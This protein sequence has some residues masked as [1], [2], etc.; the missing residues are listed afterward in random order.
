MR[1]LD[2]SAG[3]WMLWAAIPCLLISIAAAAAPPPPEAKFY[4][5]TPHSM[6]PSPDGR[7]LAFGRSSSEADSGHYAMTFSVY[8]V[9]RGKTTELGAYNYGSLNFGPR[10][11][12]SPNGELLAYYAVV[13]DVLQ[14]RVWDRKQGRLLPGTIPVDKAGAAELQI[15]QWTPDGRYV[16]C[17]SNANPPKKLWEEQEGDNYTARLRAELVGQRPAKNGI[18][19]LGTAALESPLKGKFGADPNSSSA[20]VSRTAARQVAA[21][22]VKTG[23]VQVLAQGEEFVQLQVSD[24]GKV[25]VAG[26]LDAHGD[27]L[28]Y[29]LPL[30]DGPTPTPLRLLFKSSQAEPFQNF[31]LSPSGRYA[32]Y[33]VEGSGEIVL[34]D[35]VAGSKRNLTAGVA[36]LKPDAPQAA[37]ERIAARFDLPLYKGKFGLDGG[38]A[39]VWTKDESALIVRRTIAQPSVTAPQRVE[40]WRVLCADGTARRIVDESTFSIVS[41]ANCHTRGRV[42]CLAGPQGA[43]LALVRSP[44]PN[45]KE[46]RSLSYA[47]IDPQSGAVRILRR[48]LA[49]AGGDNFMTAQSTGDV[50]SVEDSISQPQTLWWTSTANGTA[51]PI[52]RSLSL[53]NPDPPPLLGIAQRLEWTSAS[54]EPLFGALRLPFDYREGERLP[55]LLDVYPGRRGLERSRH[56]ILGRLDFLRT[57]GHFAILT[58]DIPV[59]FGSGHVCADIARYATEALDAAVATGRIDGARAAVAGLSYGGYSVNCIVTHTNRFR[60]AMSEAGP[61][62]LA[63]SHALGGRGEWNVTKSWQWETP[64]RI[65]AESPVY[66]LDKVRTPV[67]FLTGKTDLNNALQE[68]EMYF[69]LLALNRPAA[70]VSYDNAGHGDYNRFPDFW[71]RVLQWFQT[72][73][74]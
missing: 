54:G 71:P 1:L 28:I 68:Y 35:L 52:A 37:L 72:Y 50:V 63:S 65:V 7:W 41:W 36:P 69:G 16:L 61:S 64:E 70:L 20:G 42:A 59:K 46:T 33:L 60:A 24:D 57:L 22:D 66:H 74:K 17:L 62:D 55:I 58:P 31:N 40:L 12:W 23:V 34:V 48:T 18:T 11:V 43:V 51:K 44:R 67:L 21:L 38:D 32:A 25:A 2:C 47:R 6:S 13:D 49:S 27:F 56:F 30:P 73:L 15:P 29:A 14:L 19:L 10:P 53:I 5:L 8:D 9:A 3:R 4:Q 45:E 26:A 39:P